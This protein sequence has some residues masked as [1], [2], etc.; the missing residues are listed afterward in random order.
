MSRAH[1]LT[2]NGKLVTLPHEIEFGDGSNSYTAE[3]VAEGGGVW[4]YVYYDGDRMFRVPG[5]HEIIAYQ[6]MVGAY[7]VGVNRGE[8]IGAAK[9]LD[10]IQDA[11]GI[12]PNARWPDPADD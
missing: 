11:L 7:D 10:Q 6:A 4:S 1:Q 12:T 5:A 8:R 9:K 2:I 3:I